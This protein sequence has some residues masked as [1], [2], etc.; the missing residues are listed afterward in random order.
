MCR[1]AA[2]KRAR[3]HDDEVNVTRVILQLELVELL[4]FDNEGAR[5]M[6][7][8]LLVRLYVSL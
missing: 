8:V 6:L 4:R 5:F 7:C 2:T 3:I 1:E